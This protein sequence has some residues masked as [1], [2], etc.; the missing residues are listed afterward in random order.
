MEKKLVADVM[1]SPSDTG[2]RAAA[3]N[4]QGI[5]PKNFTL[6]TEVE[7]HP[8]SDKNVSNG[9]VIFQEDTEPESKHKQALK[10]KAAVNVSPSKASSLR[11]SSNFVENQNTGNI[12]ANTSFNIP[13]SVSCLEDNF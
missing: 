8:L 12:N 6:S 1:T 13:G 3:E 5:V 7:V 10:D 11:T 4:L 9:C 2:K